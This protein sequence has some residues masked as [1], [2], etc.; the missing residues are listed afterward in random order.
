MCAVSA[1]GG[2]W[3][4][5]LPTYPS[6]PTIIN[7]P[8]EVSKADFDALRREVE[9]LKNLLMAAKKFDDATGQPDCEMDEKVALIKKIAAIVGVDLGDVFGNHS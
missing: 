4:Q 9:E 8:S 3:Q 5:Q 6:Y 2:Y 1:V 7:N